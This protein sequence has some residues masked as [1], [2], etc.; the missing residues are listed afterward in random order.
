MAVVVTTDVELQV[1]CSVSFNAALVV[2]FSKATGGNTEA[3]TIK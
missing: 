1:F 2:P 3:N